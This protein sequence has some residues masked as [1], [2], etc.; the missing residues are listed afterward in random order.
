MS[1]PVV[2][3]VELRQQ[4][5]VELKHSLPHVLV[6]PPAEGRGPGAG[7][8]RAAIKRRSQAQ[9]NGSP[10]NAGRLHSKEGDRSWQPGRAMPS[11]DMQ[12]TLIR[13]GCSPGQLVV[14][15]FWHMPPSVTHRVPA[16][17]C[18]PVEYFEAQHC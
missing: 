3:V 10:S 5:V 9:R 17:H 6:E 1:S 14:V 18:L 4:F 11:G 7:P 12:W 8:K 15:A 16:G 13:K 2:L